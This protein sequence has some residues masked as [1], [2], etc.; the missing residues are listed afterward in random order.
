MPHLKMVV[1]KKL[2]KAIGG[3]IAK[4]IPGASIIAGVAFG[5][6]RMMEG[7]YAGAGIEIASGATGTIPIVGTAIS[8]ALDVYQYKQ[9]GQW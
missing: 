7:D 8:T 9:I 1:R 6:D 3:S 4:K 2:G 5:I